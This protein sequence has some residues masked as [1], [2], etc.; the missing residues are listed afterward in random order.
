MKYKNNGV[1][2]FFSSENNGVYVY[3]SNV[4]PKL[5]SLFWVK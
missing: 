1:F 3:G 4:E 2:F 5:C